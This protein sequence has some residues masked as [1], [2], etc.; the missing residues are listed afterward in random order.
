MDRASGST[1]ITRKDQSCAPC[2]LLYLRVYSRVGVW[3]SKGSNRREGRHGLPGVFLLLHLVPHVDAPRLRASEHKASP[4]Q[5]SAIIVRDS[6]FWFDGFRWFARGGSEAGGSANLLTYAGLVALLSLA[7]MHLLNVVT[8]ELT[9]L[10]EPSAHA[11]V[12]TWIF[13]NSEHWQNRL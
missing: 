13:P 7:Y 5:L 11:G 3:V 12:D 9:L 6:V 10:E 2:V 4:R 1:H 8:R